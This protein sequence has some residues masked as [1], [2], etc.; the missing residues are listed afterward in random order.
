MDALIYGIHAAVGFEHRWEQAVSDLRH[1]LGGRV[2]V[3]ARHDFAAGRGEWLY[4]SPVNP[5]EREGPMPPSTPCAI[6][7]SSPAWS[8]VRAG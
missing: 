8:I 2:A 3:L 5:S 7:G 6:R 4:E 1:V